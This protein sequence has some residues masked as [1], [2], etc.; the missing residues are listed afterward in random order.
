M[1]L[2]TK[3]T[4]GGLTWS[5][6]VGAGNV[7]GSSAI[8]ASVTADP[9]NNVNLVFQALDDRAAGTRPSAGVDAY[10]TYFTQSTN[11]GASFGNPLKLST[12]SSAPNGSSTNGLTGQFL[13][14][15]ITALSDSH[16]RRIFAV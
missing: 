1:V 16:G 15:S 3:S 2:A 10:D 12:A 14:D 11:G 6:P 4:N 5:A 9:N 13:G 7:S 8:F